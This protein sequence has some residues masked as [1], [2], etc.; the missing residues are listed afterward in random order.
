MIN[1]SMTDKEWTLAIAALHYLSVDDRGRKDEYYDECMELI[2][3]MRKA[4]YNEE[5]GK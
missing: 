1:I 4:R 3:K 2:H 5:E